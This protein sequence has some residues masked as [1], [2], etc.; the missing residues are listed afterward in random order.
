METRINRLNIC[1]QYHLK[2][3]W[4]YRAS[5]QVWKLQQHQ[6]ETHILEKKLDSKKRYL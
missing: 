5:E 6:Q 4:I 2:C 3:P 1:V